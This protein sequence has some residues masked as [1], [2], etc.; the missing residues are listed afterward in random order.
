MNIQIKSS[1]VTSAGSPT[2]GQL[3]ELIYLF[4]SE[5]ASEKRYDTF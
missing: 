3:D 1:E 2:N 4:Y 5:F